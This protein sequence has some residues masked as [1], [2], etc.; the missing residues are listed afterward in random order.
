M[1]ERHRNQVNVFISSMNNDQQK[2]I[3]LMSIEGEVDIQNIKV[4]K[5]LVK[6]VLQEYLF[7]P[8]QFIVDIQSGQHSDIPFKASKYQFSIYG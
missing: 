3:N 4:G 7:I 6:P 5:Y 8:S 1:E 2:R